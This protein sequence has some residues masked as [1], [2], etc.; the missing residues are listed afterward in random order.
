MT[1]GERLPAFVLSSPGWEE[2]QGCEGRR[3]SSLEGDGGTAS[4]IISWQSGVGG[5]DGGEDEGGAGVNGVGVTG[6]GGRVGDIAPWLLPD[7]IGDL[8]LRVVRVSL[9]P[10][11]GVCCW[12]WGGRRD[13]AM[14]VV[15]VVD[16]EEEEEEYLEEAEVPL[17]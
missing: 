12:G 6:E 10:E 16:E 7:I 2:E 17:L 14:V 8:G 5:G 1:F 4:G 3:G 9:V 11:I 15:V 13:G